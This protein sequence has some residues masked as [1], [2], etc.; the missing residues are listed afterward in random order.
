MRQP[1]RSFLQMGPKGSIPHPFPSSLPYLFPRS[2]I[3]GGSW[4]GEV[5]SV[6]PWPSFMPLPHLPSEKQRDD[7]GDVVS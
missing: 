6:G 3:L 2:G 7:L 4:G 5:P 1:V